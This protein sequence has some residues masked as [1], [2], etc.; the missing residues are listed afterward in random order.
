MNRY[1]RC[2]MNAPAAALA[3]ALILTLLSACGKEH[4]IH[5][6]AINR[7]PVTEAPAKPDGPVMLVGRIATPEPLQD[8]RI[9]FRSGANEAGA[10][11]YH[12]WTERPDAM[13]RDLLV[14]RLHATGHYAHVQETPS[15]T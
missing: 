6:Y 14:Q 7:P 15:S 2:L 12:R 11:E 13:V 5:Y 1:C 4:P 10:Y 9:R 3:G 8:A